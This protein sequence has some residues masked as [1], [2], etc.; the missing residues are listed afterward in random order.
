MVGCPR[1]FN[2]Y[3]LVRIAKNEVMSSWM[4]EVTRKSSLVSNT[5]S[6]AAGPGFTYKNVSDY[7]GM[8]W[9]FDKSS[10]SPLL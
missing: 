8:K 6:W 4:E 3:F 7:Y 10:F 1:S 2:L 9:C 5:T